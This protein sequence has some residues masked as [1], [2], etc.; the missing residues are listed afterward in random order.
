MLVMIAYL[1]SICDVQM[2][3]RLKTIGSCTYIL[4]LK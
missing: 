3:G 1:D 4:E 2:L